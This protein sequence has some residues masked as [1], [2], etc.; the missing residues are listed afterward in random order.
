M[1][2]TNID[3]PIRTFPKNSLEFRE[4]NKRGAYRPILS[5][6]PCTQMVEI[7][8]F[9]KSSTIIMTGLNIAPLWI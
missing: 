4:K 1:N 9:V 2:S 7:G 8:L 5:V 3:D 6:Y